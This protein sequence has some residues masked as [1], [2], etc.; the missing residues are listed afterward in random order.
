MPQP[1][2]CHRSAGRVILGHRSYGEWAEF[3]PGSTIQPFATFIN[4]VAKFVATSAPLQPEW[5][6][7][8][9]VD[10][11]LVDFVRDL[12]AWPGGDIGV[13]ASISMVEACLPRTLSTRS[14]S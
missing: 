13:H 8:S 7:A 3:W 14:G 4:G 9:V 2:F 10:G 12:K 1:R 6:N 11:G 5:A